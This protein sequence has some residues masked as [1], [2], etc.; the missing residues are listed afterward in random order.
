MSTKYS[1][2]QR[3]ELREYRERMARKAER[4]SQ[5][6]QRYRTGYAVGYFAIG[7][8]A[9]LVAAAVCVTLGVAS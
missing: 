1:A 3:K 6:E 2:Q 5:I 8:M 9:V 4:P 7:V